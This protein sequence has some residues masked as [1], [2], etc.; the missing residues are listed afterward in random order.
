MS[1]VEQNAWRA[2]MEAETRELR[3]AVDVLFG[4]MDAQGAKL[5][6]ITAALH[7]IRGSAGPSWSA[8][9]AVIKDGAFLFALVVGGILYLASATA[10]KGTSDLEARL[11]RLETIISMAAA[12]PRP[13]PGAYAP[14]Y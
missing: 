8:M 3:R 14:T 1:A 11:T 10:S 9:L 6:A 4:K 13:T 5:D 7:E 2:G 12:K